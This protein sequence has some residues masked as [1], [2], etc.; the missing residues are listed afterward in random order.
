MGF[1]LGR[2]IVYPFKSLDGMSV[3][4]ARITAAGILENDRTYAIFDSQ[5]KKVNGK[6]E[7]KIHRLR[8]RFDPSVSEI[9]IWPEG[10]SPAR[11][12]LS[13]LPP[14]NRWLSDYFG[15]EVAVQCDPVSGF[16]DDK[17][18]Y[19]PTIISSASLD[20]IAGWYPGLAVD[21]VR[22]RFRA[23]LE[24]EGEGIQ[25]FFEDSLFG[26]AG[27][28]RPFAIGHVRLLGH[29]PCQRCVVPTRDPDS[30]EGLSG[31]QKEFMERR[32]ATLPAWANP[33]RFNHFY[34][35]ALNTSTPLTEAGKS[36]RVGDALDAMPVS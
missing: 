10:G 20:A 1:V 11:F 19:G 14:L 2:I 6:R 30:G 4:E 15:Y 17:E 34:R 23:N 5:G 27:E 21:S 13:E 36:L 9:E 24:L 12:V 22:R 31:F 3:S 25:P 35:F 26:A 18:A 8:S 7:A 28:L 16:P 32:K 33:T 29:N